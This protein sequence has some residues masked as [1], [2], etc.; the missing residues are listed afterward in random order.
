MDPKEDQDP[1]DYYDEGEQEELQQKQF[2]TPR[3]LKHHPPPNSAAYTERGH[4]KDKVIL[5]SASYDHTIRFWNADKGFCERIVQ[6]NDQIHV[7]G[8][9]EE[10]VKTWVRPILEHA[11]SRLVTHTFTP[12]IFG[13]PTQLDKRNGNH[14]KSRDSCYCRLSAH[15]PV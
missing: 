6:N 15:S 13:S 3:S 4:Y 8:G 2:H 1:N 7:S 5:A 14:A 12:F 9:V 10:V 11:L